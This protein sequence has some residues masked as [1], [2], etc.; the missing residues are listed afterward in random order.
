MLGKES[1]LET[2]RYAKPSSVGDG[3]VDNRM[4]GR[5]H[6]PASV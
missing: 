6:C 5:T 2:E 1:L 3:W 4:R